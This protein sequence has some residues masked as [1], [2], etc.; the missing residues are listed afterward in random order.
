M[1]SK[2]FRARL[3]RGAGA[4]VLYDLITGLAA[5]C[6]IILATLW[7]FSVTWIHLAAEYAAAGRA[8]S[9]PG[10]LELAW[11]GSFITLPLAAS[12]IYLAIRAYGLPRDVGRTGGRETVRG[13]R[14]RLRRTGGSQDP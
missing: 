11:V 4:F 12:V 3:A 7:L 8:F 10:Q 2:P 14:A 13:I 9:S 6:V 5:Y 1:E